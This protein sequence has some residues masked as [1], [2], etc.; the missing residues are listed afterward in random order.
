[1]QPIGGE[2][3]PDTD[4]REPRHVELVRK[5]FD[6]KDDP[7]SMY[8]VERREAINLLA[9][10]KADELLDKMYSS[11]EG[12]Q[13]KHDLVVIEGTHEGDQSCNAHCYPLETV[14]S[15][16]L[17]FT[18]HYA[19]VLEDIRE[20]R[21]HVALASICVRI[22]VCLYRWQAKCAGQSTGA[23]WAHCCSAGSASPDGAGCIRGHLCGRSG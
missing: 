9:H 11:F 2:P 18:G 1:M 22:N 3:F 19:S 14:W 21:T 4:S 5:A 7:R 23:E 16:L 8:A 10:D 12:Y 20:S 13:A 17:Y 15:A 6:L